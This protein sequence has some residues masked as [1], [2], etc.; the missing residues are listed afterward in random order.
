MKQSNIS[1]IAALRKCLTRFA[2]TKESALLHAKDYLGKELQFETEDVINTRGHAAVMFTVYD[3]NDECRQFQ[4]EICAD[5][6]EFTFKGIELEENIYRCNSRL[7]AAMNR[8]SQI[9]SKSAWIVNYYHDNG[10]F[11]EVLVSYSTVIAAWK[12]DTN[13]I[14][15]QRGARDY[16][17]T[18]RRH[19]SDFEAHVSRILGVSNKTAVLKWARFEG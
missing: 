16:S 3:E 14:Y 5:K 9:R 10:G 11:Y 4:A 18:T 8:K 17:H 6:E 12:V 13:I 19:L 2:Y 15:L 1:K 7:A